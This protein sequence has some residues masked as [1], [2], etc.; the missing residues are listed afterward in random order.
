MSNK[1]KF[2]KLSQGDS[3]YLMAKPSAVLETLAIEIENADPGES[4]T[5]E[6]VEEDPAVVDALPEWDGF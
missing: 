6:V 5:V 4:F 3:G 2:V 1:E